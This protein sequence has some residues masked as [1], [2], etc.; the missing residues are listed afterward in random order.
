M[1]HVFRVGLLRPGPVNYYGTN[2]LL[3]RSEIR[4]ER[5]ITYF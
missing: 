4:I 5:F 2:V 3:C 1:L